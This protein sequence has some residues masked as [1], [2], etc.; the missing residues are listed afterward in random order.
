MAKRSQ[1][2]CFGTRIT[3]SKKGLCCLV[4]CC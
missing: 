1:E 3:L 2:L 4:L